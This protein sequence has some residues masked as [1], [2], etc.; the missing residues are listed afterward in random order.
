MTPETLTA[1]QRAAALGLLKPGVKALANKAPMSSQ[2]RRKLRID[3]ISRGLVES[4]RSQVNATANLDPNSEYDESFTLLPIDAIEPYWNNPRLSRNPR[5]EELKESI[6]ASGITNVL[7]VTRKGGKDQ[8]YTTYGGG[9]TRLA[10]AKEL[11]SEGD[12]RFATIKAMIKAWPG[13]SQVIAAQLSEN[14]LRGD[15]TF[16]EKAHAVQRFQEELEAERSDTVTSAELNSALR[17]TGLGYSLKTLQI[18]G[19]AVEYL[20]VLGPWLGARDVNDVL[21]PVILGILGIATKLNHLPQVKAA[22]ATVTAEHAGRLRDA[23]Q[24]AVSRVARQGRADGDGEEAAPAVALD[25]AALLADLRAA[26]S[27]ELAVEPNVLAAMEAAFTLDPAISADALRDARPIA[28]APSVQQPSHAQA[29]ATKPQGGSD[30]SP[31]WPESATRGAQGE[32]RQQPL[33]AMLA[34]VGVNTGE[35]VPAAVKPAT[36]Y[37]QQPALDDIAHAV[38]ALDELVPISDVVRFTDALPFG[39]FVDFPRTT[40]AEYAMDKQEPVGLPAAAVSLRTA[41]WRLLA[42]LSYQCDRQCTLVLPTDSVSW[43][44]F[45][46]RGRETF[47][48]ELL[49]RTQTRLAAAT[50]E[51]P[52]DD[53]S[54]VLAAPGLRAAV[55]KLLAL[56]EGARQ[57]LPERFPAQIQPM[58]GVPQ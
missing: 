16:W 43:T 23:E 31:L 41:T 58:F 15:L 40:L 29:P 53:L 13:D 46:T 17:K 24:A 25:C 8:K 9:N 50:P 45:F 6:R 38:L 22:F 18:Y 11:Y 39:Y 48:R 37:L 21:R 47:E 2:D 49:A 33:G 34:A 54:T 36:Q 57:R 26:A 3:A 10:I 12:Q 28:P 19:F 51:I 7:T 52:M 30:E 55:L 44:L 1:H 4:T 32:P 56:M 42:A 14:E 5:Y 35:T 20:S 27:R